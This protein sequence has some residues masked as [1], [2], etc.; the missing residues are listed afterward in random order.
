M[1]SPNE[2]LCQSGVG[3]RIWDLYETDQPAFRKEVVDYFKRGMPGWKPVKI[4][5]AKRIIWLR[6]ERKKGMFL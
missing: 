6:D 3:P 2:V 1:S 4:N 5:F